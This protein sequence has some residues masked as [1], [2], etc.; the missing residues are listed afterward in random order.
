MN[1][2]LIVG[3][4]NKSEMT[5]RF[6][7]SLVIVVVSICLGSVGIA[8][9]RKMS[10]ECYL[11]EAAAEKKKESGRQAHLA[12]S[13]V[14]DIP[15]NC[16]KVGDYAADFDLPNAQGKSTK[17]SSLLTK[18][19]VVLAFYRGSWC[20]FCNRELHSLQTILP[21]L[22]AKGAS[23]VAISPQLPE[24]TAATVSKNELSFDVLSDVGN[25]TAKAYGLVYS[26]PKLERPFYALLG[27]DLPKHN[28]DESFEIPLPATYII[29]KNRKIKFA[30]IDVDYKKRMSPEDI[31]KQLTLT[32]NSK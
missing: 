3:S 26:V 12:K 22:K 24:S 27:A 11:I 9:E 28:G 19:P 8:E 21:Q 13:D 4:K 23:L 15:T 29:D 2:N 30:F 6:S 7:I 31:L 10:S 17:L 1:M 18:G 16:L 32:G 14:K 5:K 20:P 25:R